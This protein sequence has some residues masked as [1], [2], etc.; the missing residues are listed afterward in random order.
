VTRRERNQVTQY[1]VAK[2]AVGEAWGPVVSTDRDEIDSITEVIRGS[3]ADILPIE[4]HRQENNTAGFDLS[5]V[6]SPVSRFRPIP[7]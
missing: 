4:W 2:R 6:I 7:L 5:P 3:K 1:H